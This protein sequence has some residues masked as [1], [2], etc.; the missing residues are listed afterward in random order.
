MRE[1]A[2]C[3][4]RTSHNDKSANTVVLCSTSSSSFSSYLVGGTKVQVRR[5]ALALPTGIH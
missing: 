3:F 1:Q 4:S 5:L 2:I